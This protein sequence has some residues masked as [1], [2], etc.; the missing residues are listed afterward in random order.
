MDHRHGRGDG[1]GDI[2]RNSGRRW[3]IGYDYGPWDSYGTWSERVLE[4]G[5]KGASP[6]G[7]FGTIT[8]DWWDV[9]WV[10]GCRK[11]REGAAVGLVGLEAVGCC[12]RAGAHMRVCVPGRGWIGMKG[13][14]NEREA[15]RA[16]S[17]AS[18]GPRQV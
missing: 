7:G 16:L 12:A 2:L 8:D 17:V 10:C 1:D 5:R 11:E 14:R 9:K 15:A 6:D 13:S 3:P 4:N 18:F